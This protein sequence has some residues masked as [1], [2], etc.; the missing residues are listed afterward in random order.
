MLPIPPVAGVRDSGECLT[1]ALLIITGVRDD[2]YREILGASVADD[3][4][5]GFWSGLFDELKDRGMKGVKQVVSDGHKG[6]QSAVSRAFWVLP[7]KGPDR[8]NKELKSRN[9]V[10]G[11]S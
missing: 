5:E 2:G 9:K 1:K 3:E 7:G 6:I 10:V 8:I 11:H 4:G